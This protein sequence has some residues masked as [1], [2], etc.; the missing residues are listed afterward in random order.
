MVV[1]QKRLASHDDGHAAIAE[2]ARLG[3]LAIDLHVRL[4]RSLHDRHVAPRVA[5]PEDRVDQRA[6][7]LRVRRDEIVDGLGQRIGPLD[8]IGR[9]ERI[10]RVVE[11]VQRLAEKLVEHV[12]LGADQIVNRR[13]GDPRLTG[14]LAHRE[15]GH[16]MTNDDAPCSAQNPLSAL[17]LMILA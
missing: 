14:E 16:A 4:H 1:I 8:R 15:R 12:H 9:L 6:V 13:H 7:K 5:H 17:G 10:E 3:G 11:R 2:N